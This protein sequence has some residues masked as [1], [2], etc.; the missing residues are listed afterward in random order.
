MKEGDLFKN[1]DII[2]KALPCDHGSETPDAVGL[3]INIEGKRIYIAGD[4]CFREDY[5]SNPEL[6]SLDVLIMPINGAFGNLNEAEGARTAK[7]INPKLTIPCHYWNFAEHG[8]NPNLFAKEMDKKYSEL[9]YVL[10]RPGETI[11]I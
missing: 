5:F 7:I 9:Q 4:T 3:L 11:S 6:D 1:N 2:V 8:G 10:M